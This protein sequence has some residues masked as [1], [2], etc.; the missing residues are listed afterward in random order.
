[1]RISFTFFWVV[2]LIAPLFAREGARGWNFDSDQTG[3]IA[4]DFTNES[5][6]WKVVADSTAPSQPN[7]LAQVAKNSG[8]AFNTALL[9]GS[10]YGDLELAVKMKAIAGKEDQGEPLMARSIGQF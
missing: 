8:S 7:V 6:E 5:G 9:K 2:L 1:M 4:R 3:S 10:N